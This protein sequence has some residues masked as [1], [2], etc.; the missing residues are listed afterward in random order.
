MEN[1]GLLHVS[2]QCVHRCAGS[3]G[4]MEVKVAIVVRNLNVI[5][6][7]K[8]PQNIAV[9]Y[10]AVCLHAKRKIH[11]TKMENTIMTW[12]SRNKFNKADMFYL[13]LASHSSIFLYD[14]TLSICFLY[15]RLLLHLICQCT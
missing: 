5:N 6:D 11:S 15:D 10:I 13:N 8:K 7:P 4:E 1:Q 2:L 3:H 14:H 9:W 12:N